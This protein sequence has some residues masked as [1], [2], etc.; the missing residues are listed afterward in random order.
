MLTPDTLPELPSE[1][2]DHNPELMELED[3]SVEFRALQWLESKGIRQGIPEDIVTNYSVRQKREVLCRL[4]E[5]GAPG[6]QL[7]RKLSRNLSLKI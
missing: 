6:F 5:G 1:Q 4:K 2:A 7:R 3:N